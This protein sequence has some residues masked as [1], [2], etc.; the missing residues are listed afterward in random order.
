M[1]TRYRFLEKPRVTGAFMSINGLLILALF[2]II[3]CGTNPVQPDLQADLPALSEVSK[4]AWQN[5]EDDFNC[6]ESAGLITA[7]DGGLIHLGWG[8]PK[9][10]L[11]FEPGS[12]SEDVVIDIT[13]CIVKGN[14]QNNFSVIEFDFGPDGLFFSPPAQIVLNAGSLNALRAPRHDGVVR[15]YFYD[16]D[17]DEWFLQQEAEIHR[18]TVT[19]EVDHF[20]KFGV[21]N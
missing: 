19:F 6:Y 7:A 10:S 2:A 5:Q 3:G 13:T 17:T 16:P 11:R 9:N 4:V 8:S 14:P 21:S 18:G 15:L 12:V 20:S 1:I